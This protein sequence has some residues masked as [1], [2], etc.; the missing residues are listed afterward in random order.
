[1]SCAEALAGAIDAGKRF[2]RHHGAIPGLRR[3]EAHVAVAA[4][5]AGLIEIVEQVDAAAGDAF[6]QGQQRIELVRGNLLV[7][8]IGF[9]LLDHAP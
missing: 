6:A 9:G 7:L 2:L 8:L 4:R 3:V 5:L 1:M